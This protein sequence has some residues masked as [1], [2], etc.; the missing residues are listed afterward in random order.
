[1]RKNPHQKYLNFYDNGYAILTFNK[2]SMIARMMLV[3]ILALTDTQ[4]TDA[5]LYCRTNDNH[6]LRP[7]T[8]STGVGAVS[9]THPIAVYPN[10]STTGRWTLRAAQGLAGSPIEITTDDGRVI[11][12]GS[13]SADVETPIDISAEP[14]GVYFLHVTAPGVNYS[15]KLIRIGSYW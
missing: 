5:V 4:S 10:P 9:P 11:Y 8:I 2:D 12:R 6:W 13:V 7:D 15:T 3:P 1:M 14:G